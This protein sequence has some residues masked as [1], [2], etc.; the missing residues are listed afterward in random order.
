MKQT[1]RY[2]RYTLEEIYNTVL[3][4]SFKDWFEIDLN[5]HIEWANVDKKEM[6]KG[7]SELI[8]QSN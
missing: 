4:R 1:K 8:K 3:T 7:L 2:K 6:M 5:E